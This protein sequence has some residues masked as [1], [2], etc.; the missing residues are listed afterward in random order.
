MRLGAGN[1][2]WCVF[3]W[4]FHRLTNRE[5]YEQCEVWWVYTRQH[6]IDFVK[7]GTAPNKQE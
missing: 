2:A 5:L 7:G 6:L 4:D 1:H 3:L